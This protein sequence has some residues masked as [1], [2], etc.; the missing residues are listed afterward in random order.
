MR[1]TS[2]ASERQYRLT[3]VARTWLML[4]LATAL[5]T[6]PAAVTATDH[7]ATEHQEVHAGNE[8]SGALSLDQLRAFSDAIN[9]IR[10][11][12]V[13]EVSDQQL[14]DAALRG[15]VAE[16]DAYSAILDA[17]QL[18]T[19]KSS[20]KGGRIGPGL[21]TEI[22]ESRLYVRRVVADSPAS[23]AGVREGDLLL[24]VDGIP[25]RGRP[26]AE[27]VAALSGP[28]G[29]TL[30]LSLRSSSGTAARNITVAR[31]FVVEPSVEASLLE[32]NVAYLVL[33]TFNR[34]S[35]DELEVALQTMR[36]QVAEGQLSAM[37][38]DLRNNRGG[39]I[40]AAMEIAD[41]FLDHGLVVHTEGRS[42]ASRLEYRALPGQ[43][44]P[45]LPLLALIN[46]RSASAAEILAGALRD[47]GR[48]L[49]FGQTTYG[50][51]S[52]Q[53]VLPLRNGKAIKL[54]TGRYLTPGGSV[55][56]KKGIAPDYEVRERA[57]QEHA[58]DADPVLSAALKY[59]R[60]TPRASLATFDSAAAA[61]G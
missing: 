59:L 41:G 4:V 18:Q 5:T 37:I 21:E 55:I 7:S 28:P 52:A 42:A 50:K 23:R 22:R 17:Q 61:G 16:L 12:Y 51:G 49:L 9:I 47:N 60:E 58:T 13:D 25:V 8:A 20:N 33:K 29:T 36:E 38:L 40:R 56:E 10:T 14:L 2:T 39:T 15:M 45:Q 48:A 6:G 3:R 24:S 57:Q 26:L 11:H 44:A 1:T 43:W 31:E 35:A 30:Q 46:G 34:R 32:N 53:A 19:Q 54:T 27:S